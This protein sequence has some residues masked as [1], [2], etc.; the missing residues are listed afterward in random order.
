M[1]SSILS[2]RFPL[3][4]E[5]VGAEDVAIKVLR[6]ENRGD[7]RLTFPNDSVGQR[8][9]WSAIAQTIEFS[10]DRFFALGS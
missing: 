6:I 1:A 8:L 3:S 5:K 4:P 10:A 9:F 2:T 7:R